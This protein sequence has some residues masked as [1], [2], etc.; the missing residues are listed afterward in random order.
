[1]SQRTNIC[2]SALLLLAPCLVAQQP[3]SP[4][5]LPPPEDAFTSTQLIMW[6]WIQKPQP[7][8]QPLPPPD[9][10]LPPSGQ[11]PVQSANPNSQPVAKQ[12]FIGKVVKDGDHLILRT[13]DGATYQLDEQRNLSQYEDKTVRING[14]LDA[15][16]NTIHVV[17]IALLS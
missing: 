3:Q 10:P 15:T 11:Q 8:P 14:T 9:K 13:S 1:M 4:S 12:V 7:T 6:T 16:T 17:K 5:R 2:C